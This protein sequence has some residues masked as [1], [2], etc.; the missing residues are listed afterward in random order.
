M[1]FAMTDSRA[2]VLTVTDVTDNM[3]GSQYIRFAIC[4][5][6]ENKT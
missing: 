1:A 6:L 5:K 4:F 2:E 3:Y